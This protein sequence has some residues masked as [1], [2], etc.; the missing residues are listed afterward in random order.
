MITPQE[1]RDIANQIT[2]LESQNQLKA[3]DQAIWGAAALGKLSADITRI[4][5]LPCVE[6]YI[7]RAGYTITPPGELGTSRI[8]SW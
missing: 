5:L 4:P 2:T 6:E 3:I 7:E 8:I 1:A